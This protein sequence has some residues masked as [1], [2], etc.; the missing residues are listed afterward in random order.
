VTLVTERYSRNEGLFGAEGQAMIAAIAVAIVGLGG[1]GAHVAQQLAFLGV[2]KYGLVDFDIVTESSLNRLVGA[3]EGDVAARTF[4][5]AVAERSIRTIK[6]LSTI[7]SFEGKIATPAAEEVIAAADVVFGCVD[8]DR[9]RLELTDVCAR[10]A[11]PYFDLA[12]DTAGEHHEIYGGR[13]VLCDGTRC[14]VCLPELLDQQQIA[15]EAL[16]VPHREVDRRIY[17]VERAALGGTGPS[18]VSIN[19]VVASLA[20]TEFMAMVTGLREPASQLTYRADLG[21]VR[22][23][24][25]GPS[26]DC[27]FC[28]GLWG[29]ALTDQ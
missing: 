5:T 4:K 14:L 19:G 1:L 23:S 24:S 28:S 11:K 16:S 15:L 21:I 3:T 9:P 6:S 20:V 29:S 13:V 12:T 26:S 17:G 7:T 18:V 27:Y 25:D 10:F 2:E 22:K 8:H